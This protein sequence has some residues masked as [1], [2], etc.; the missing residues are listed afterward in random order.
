MIAWTDLLI[1]LISVGAV[2]G[3]GIWKLSKKGSD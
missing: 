2:C 3:L 1:V